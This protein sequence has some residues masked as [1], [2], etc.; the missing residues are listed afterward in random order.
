MIDIEELKLISKMA[1]PGPWEWWTSDSVLR[2]TAK[3]LQNGTVVNA[4]VHNN[5]ADITCHLRNRDYIAAANP[6]T[7][8]ALIAEIERLRSEAIRRNAGGDGGMS[9]YGSNGI[10]NYGGGG[11]LINNKT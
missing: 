11:I 6:A 7:M 1:T 3:C 4:Y 9:K 8:L 5:I 2:L 10:E